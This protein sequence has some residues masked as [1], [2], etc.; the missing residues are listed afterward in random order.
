M[1]EFID[2]DNTDINK[3]CFVAIAMQKSRTRKFK[4]N[5]ITLKVKYLLQ[6]KIYL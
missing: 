5:L 2:E 1:K 4:F 6:M 3:I